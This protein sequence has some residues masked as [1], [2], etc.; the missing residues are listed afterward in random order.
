MLTIK[1]GLGI[2]IFIITYFF[3]LQGKHPQSLVTMIGGSLMVMIGALNQEEALHSIGSNLEIFLLLIGLMMVVEV[4]S[5]SGIFQWIAIKVAQKAKGNPL[6]IMIFLSA[7]TALCSAFLDNVTTVLLIVPITILLAKTL[8]INPFGFIM[9]QIFACN[10]GGAATM[11]GDPP[12]LIIASMGK[13]S[14][15]DFLINL[16]PLIIINMIVLL[17]TGKYMFKNS[18]KVTRKQRAIVMD[19]KPNRMI[20]N[21]KLLVQSLILFGFI[22][23]GFLTNMITEIGLAI[24]S[25]TGSVFLLFISKKNPEEIYRKVEWETLFFFGGLFVLVEGVDKLGIINNLGDVV[26][27]LGGGNVKLTAIIVLLISLI[28]SPILG[29]VPYTL[30]FS[31]IILAISPFMD[32]NPKVLWWA[33]SIG[34]CLGGNMTAIGGAANIVALSVAEKAGIKIS[35]IKFF[36]IAS[37]IVLESAILSIVYIYFM[38]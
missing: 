34:A 24:I 26:I 2:A 21:K 30:S 5:E 3:I 1:L 22:I 9:M 17:I 14:F 18:F 8:E 35:S 7:I 38:Y 19:M 31:K 33:L 16:S 12:N 25:I 11:I 15:N 4:M 32:G 20:K 6:R 36:K 10:I 28:L 23:L 37:I 13:L 27:F 29:S